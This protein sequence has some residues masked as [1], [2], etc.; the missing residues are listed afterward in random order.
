MPCRSVYWLLATTWTLA[1]GPVLGA[2]PAGERID[3]QRE[4][5]PL[6]AE[7]CLNCHGPDAQNREADFRLDTALALQ[8]PDA[9]FPGQAAR[10][11]LIARI[12]S[13]D[14][15]FRMPPPQSGKRLTAKQVGV[16]RQ[17]VDEGAIWSEHW[18]FQTARRPPQPNHGLTDWV[19]SPLDSFVAARLQQ[20]QLHPSPPADLV[21]L[22][23]R[24]A[25]DLTGLPPRPELISETLQDRA[26]EA[27]DRL[28]DRLLD[29]PHY[30]ERLALHWLDL[31]RYG[32]SDGYHDDTP[33]IVHQFR[34]YAIRSFNR[35]KPF[36]QFTIEQL[37][38]DLLPAASSEQRIA[39]AFHRL[40]PTSSEGGADA[41]EYH[42]KY[43][44]DRVNTTATV[45]LGVTLQCTECHDHKYDPFTTREF[46]QLFAFFNQVPEDVLFRG[47][48]APPVI[49]TPDDIQRLQQ[50]SFRERQTELE[51]ELARQMQVP[52]PELADSQQA[53]E[54]G[55]AQGEFAGAKLSPW[56]AIGPFFE[57]PGTMP[58]DFAYPP[59]KEIDLE[60]TYDNGKLR[61]LEK[62]EW[63]D[64]K[65][66]YL[67]GDKCA[68][69]A[70][71]TIHVA[72][73]QP[74]TLFL[75]SDD[76]IKVWVNGKLVHQNILVRI[77]APN[78]DRVPIVLE[79][80]E[81]RILLKIVNLQG[82]YGF[83][84]STK[85]KEKDERIEAAIALA[86]MPPEQRSA[87]QQR[88]LRELFLSQFV[89]EISDAAAAVADVQQQR[90]ALERSIPKLR[91]MADLPE[92]RPTHILVRGDFRV[93]GDQ[94]EPG[95]P[96][97][98]GPLPPQE[99]ITRLALAK[100]LVSRQQ[101]LTARVVVNRFWQM[102][103][104]QGL[105]RTV[106][107]F[108]VRGEAPTHPELLDWLAVEFMESGWDV[109]HLMRLI[110]TSATY[111]QSSV[112]SAELRER[113]PENR[114]LARGPR[115][116]LPAEMVRDQA[117]AVSG[118]L[119]RRIGG[120]SVKPYQPG[121]LWRE[122]AY[123]DQPDRAYVQDHG[124]PL[125]R[126]G[127]YTFWKRSVHYPMFAIFDAPNREVCA[128][129]RPV[130][131]TPLQA[132]VM[133]NDV[134]FVEAARVLAQSILLNDN[135]AFETRL[136][137]AIWSVLGRAP[138]EQE[139]APLRRLHDRLKD[140][141]RTHLAEAMAVTQIGEFPRPA[142]LEIVEL[143]VWTGICQSL[144][145][146]D[147][148]LTQE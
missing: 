114:W 71:R 145:N 69:Y 27:Y 126:R 131:N 43:A 1:S 76:G 98:L 121:D 134:A 78:Q 136:S 42:A 26:P 23:R 140:N 133:L 73:R 57:Q 56:Q 34:D 91:V 87:E 46:Y 66:L 103:F 25:L 64:G 99:P 6:F 38:G 104:G 122:M 90:A 92:R 22:I 96:A 84:F 82:G 28:V 37:A 36:D 74:M 95:V 116:R 17:W 113:D 89:P 15:E 83:Y 129:Q 4:V 13:D 106:N 35:N 142:G 119:V 33:R 77:V 65:P 8:H 146:L 5:R 143:A 81:N 3:F 110:V 45:W 51:A 100:W 11:E 14:P 72:Y 30:G 50:A 125:Y 148:A 97:L 54:A 118:L 20:E 105:V 109:K 107:D 16:L 59:E 139:F 117:L 29:S 39:S 130:T 135:P 108:G 62:P 19:Q 138:R 123:G 80:G 86:R 132:L 70:Y 67:P 47:N 137:Q 112:V 93:P 40:G 58:F 9:I 21:T 55:I 88:Q 141:Y 111:R 53:W 12:S 124:E 120:P 18:A 49:A 61:W 2:P 75:G 60:T 147:E 128:A 101:P 63:V 115:H 52:R 41:A 127:M 31:A 44:V 7:F 48:D 94:V 85:E 32:D 144:L 10:S 24:L 102:L 68:T 79:P